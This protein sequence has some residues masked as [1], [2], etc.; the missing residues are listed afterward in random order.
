MFL[1]LLLVLV[2]GFD[3]CAA[4]CKT[5]LRSVRVGRLDKRAAAATAPG[6]SPDK[7]ILAK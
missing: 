7:A 1:L 2:V 3:L 5:R 6:T 4:S